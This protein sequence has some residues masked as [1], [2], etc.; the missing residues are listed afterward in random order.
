[1]LKRK[2]V[3]KLRLVNAEEVLFILSSC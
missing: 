1:M 3:L 2:F